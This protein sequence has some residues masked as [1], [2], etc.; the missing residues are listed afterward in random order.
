MGFVE[1]DVAVS[2]CLREPLD[3][4]ALIV[5]ENRFSC[6]YQHLFIKGANRLKKYRVRPWVHDSGTCT[7]HVQSLSS[8]SSPLNQDVLYTGLLAILHKFRNT[9]IYYRLIMVC[10]DKY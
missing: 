1:T 8:C 6:E 5:A 7:K 2:N 3:R 10:T 9:I 4:P